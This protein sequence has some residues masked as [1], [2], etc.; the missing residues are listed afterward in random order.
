MG[1][2][3]HTATYRVFSLI[4]F[5]NTITNMALG[6]RQIFIYQHN[7][8]ASESG[9][10]IITSWRAVLVFLFLPFAF[11]SDSTSRSAEKSSRPNIVLVM[12]DD[13]GWGQTGYN[14]HP[15]LKTPN[16]DAMAAAGLR[17]NRF[18]AGGPVCSPTRASVLTGRSHRR[19]GVESHGYALRL[20]EKTIAQSLKN[21]GYA[22]GHFG[23]WH[24]NGM[25]GPGVPILSGDT[26]APDAFG[27]DTWLSVT[28][29][30]DR[31]PLLSRQGAVE[32]FT[33]DSSEIIVD[34]AL[35]FISAQAS[36][37]QP[38]FTVIWFGSPHLPFMADPNDVAAFAALDDD[39]REQLGE[40]VA[41][42]RSIGALRTGLRTLEIADDTLVWF[43]SDNGG[44][45]NLLPETVGGLRGFKGSV[46]EGGI[47]VP[48]IIEWPRT[49]K[50]RITDFPAVAMDIVPTIAEIVGLPDSDF[51][52]PQD[53]M[54]LTE[55][56]Q[57][58]LLQ[59]T[60]PIPFSYQGET[61]IIDNDYKLIHHKSAKNSGRKTPEYE[62]YN[63]AN[64][65]HEENNVVESELE[66]AARIKEF[67]RAFQKSMTA[68]I[69]GEDYPA[70]IVTPGN[71]ESSQ[72]V[73]LPAYQP[74]LE[75]WK[76]RPEYRSRIAPKLAK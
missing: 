24:L 59:R 8:Q 4:F 45:P 13:Q 54:S 14:H 68:S 1:I 2:S 28:N 3:I 12:T 11:A 72:W 52:E 56:F 44:L 43:I 73:D 50:P 25:A 63:L 29:F 23:K 16:L 30:F 36:A 71:P 9:R 10:R 22:T 55:L 67:M 20:Q 17:F 70:G 21:A 18:Y 69:D 39:S 65:P 64:D 19:A 32:E 48:G 66:T 35:K 41:M 33:G 6:D 61:A 76:D 60:K 7:A 57:T 74:Y 47:R 40:L 49:I 15:L 34:A 53:G 5:S 26:H 75:S 37:K 51:I 27:F 31:N 58:E 38:S 42:D 62:L 46:Y